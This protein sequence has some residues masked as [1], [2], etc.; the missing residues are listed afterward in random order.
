MAATVVGTNV[1]A[2]SVV[3]ATVVAATVVAATVVAA[4]VVAASVVAAAVVAAM[5]VAAVVV[6]VVLGRQGRCLWS[7]WSSRNL[8]VRPW[9][10]PHGGGSCGANR[11]KVAWKKRKQKN[12]LYNVIYNLDQN[13]RYTIRAN[14]KIYN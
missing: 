3:I 7:K 2:G 14:S 6:L 11:P 9:R 8:K 12:K 4:A 10:S 13:K 5:V 1:V